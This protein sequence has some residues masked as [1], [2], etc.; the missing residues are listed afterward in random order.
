M[1]FVTRR[2]LDSVWHRRR[3]RDLSWP[4][5]KP[6]RTRYLFRWD[7]VAD[8]FPSPD[9]PC[10]VRAN[11]CDCSP[12]N[13]LDTDISSMTNLDL[14]RAKDRAEAATNPS[15]TRHGKF[16][17]TRDWR[18]NLTNQAAGG[19]DN[20]TEIAQ[21]RNC[22][23]LVSPPRATNVR[24]VAKRKT[25]KTAHSR[26]SLYSVTRRTCARETYLRCLYVVVDR[27]HVRWCNLSNLSN[28]SFRRTRIEW[29]ELFLF[30]HLVEFWKQT[31]HV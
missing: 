26:S 3:R 23:H 19:R 2:Y 4:I 16:P 22:D 13:R 1:W 5:E 28:L 29:F 27:R 11:L 21:S 18:W 31:R 24:K 10:L 6:A 7:P 30:S 14:D 9:P 20:A 17:L 12:F 25:R 8:L 15:S